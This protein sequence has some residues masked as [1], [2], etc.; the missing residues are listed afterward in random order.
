LALQFHVHGEAS[1]IHIEQ[2]AVR[3][4][5]GRELGVGFITWF[6][7][8]RHDWNNSSHDW[9]RNNRREKGAE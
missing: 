3:W 1:P 5:R 9:H 2:A 7:R 4:S 6:H 8:S